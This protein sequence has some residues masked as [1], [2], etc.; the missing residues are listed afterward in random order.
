MSW[1]L[2]WQEL[3]VH[4]LL[5]LAW[6]HEHKH[7]RP[8]INCCS[9]EEWHEPKHSPFIHFRRRRRKPPRDISPQ[10][11]EG[12]VCRFVF[13]TLLT[14]PFSGHEQK[15]KRDLV[16]GVWVVF[17][18]ALTAFGITCT[19]E[20][21]PVCPI[22]HCPKVGEMVVSG[23]SFQPWRYSLWKRSQLWLLGRERPSNLSLHWYFLVISIC[24]NYCVQTA[25]CLK[26]LAHTEY[27]QGLNSLVSLVQISFFFFL[28]A[29][30]GCDSLRKCNSVRNSF[31]V[32][33]R[34]LALITWSKE[35]KLMWCNTE[36]P[37]P[38][39]KR[40][41][42]LNQ[43][44][45]GTVAVCLREEAL[46]TKKNLVKEK[47]CQSW[48]ACWNKLCYS[49]LNCSWG[50]D[51]CKYLWLRGGVQAARRSSGSSVQP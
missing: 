44:C 1:V 9:S 34:Q 40:C 25:I 51:L 31:A 17:S 41:F 38:I 18:K 12:I 21:S 16:F 10:S 36:M 11:L 29:T 47:R 30:A 4:T 27:K 37:C 5:P 15:K 33:K 49:H 14:C 26:N 20:M 2:W 43:C 22:L 23:N 3:P 13:W 39:S 50:Q 32:F 35:T 48:N 8:D 46:L 6:A 45:G 42:Q 7:A 24:A 19:V 28:N